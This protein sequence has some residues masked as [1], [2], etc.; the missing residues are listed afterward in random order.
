MPRRASFVLV[1]ED[2]WVSLLP[3]WFPALWLAVSFVLAHVSGW[4]ALARRFRTTARP[5][6]GLRRWISGQLGPFVRYGG[7]LQVATAPEGLFLSVF[8]PFRA[9][10]P[11]LLVPWEQVRLA[12]ERQGVLED[13]V[14]LELGQDRRRL[15]LH[16]PVGAEVRRALEAAARRARGDAVLSRES[17]PG[18]T[19]CPYCHGGLAGRERTLECPA[20][21]SPHHAG[22]FD[23]HG[24][25]AV[26]GCRQAPREPARG[27]REKA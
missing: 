26:L 21:N 19:R 5:T 17:S 11:A 15:W 16:G 8:W 14:L 1:V 23:E 7:V 9:W 27:S 3:L 10:Q 4:A 20:C 12:E 2:P 13:R 18:A 25:C 6:A 22:C 24:G